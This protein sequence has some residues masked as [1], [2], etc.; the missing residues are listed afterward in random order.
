M[1]IKE[2]LSLQIKYL[3]S[4]VALA[5]ILI[6]SFAGFGLAY[7]GYQPQLT[8]A[9]QEI[10]E[11]NSTCQSLIASQ[12]TLKANYSYL[13]KQYTSLNASVNALQTRVD[14]L[15]TNYSNLLKQYTSL[16]ASLNALQKNYTRLQ[17]QYT[18]INASLNTLKTSFNILQNQVTSLNA[19]LNALKDYVIARGTGSSYYVYKQNSTY[20]AQNGLNGTVE[21]HDENC[22]AVL[23]YAFS[24]VPR[25]GTMLLK[26]LGSAVDAYYVNS[27][28]YPRSDTTLASENKMV[29]I[30]LE[31]NSNEDVISLFNVANVQIRDI[32][33]YGNR[34][35]NTNGSGIAISSDHSYDSNQVIENVLIEDCPDMGIWVQQWPRNNVFENVQPCYCGK[36]GVEIDSSDQ[37]L[38]DV[39][40]GW[41][42][43]SGF[44]VLGMDNYLTN[45]IS[46]GS[47]EKETVE[48]NGFIVSNYRNMFIGCDA[49]ANYGGGFVLAHANQSMLSS[50]VARDNGQANNGLRIAGRWGFDLYNTESTILTGCVSTNAA[51][52]KTQDYGFCEGGNSDYNVVTDCNFEGNRI[53]A[54]FALVGLYSVI[55]DT[56]G[57][58]TDSF[59]LSNFRYIGASIAIG[60]ADAYRDSTN[61]TSAKGEI[62]DFHVTIG[63]SNMSSNEN[64][65]V[66]VQGLN[67][68]GTATSFE[69]SRN[70]NGVYILTE[71]DISGLWSNNTMLEA[72]LVSAKTTENATQA[73][74]SVY[75]WGSGN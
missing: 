55:R 9:L 26:P 33:I 37:H 31:N 63:W 40:S 17:N 25:G 46:W 69:T 6:A 24:H 54:V 23:S 3:I 28:I 32:T 4:V 11:L 43:L 53:G 57:Y 7:L 50:C 74:V 49:S 12:D 14:T 71:N 58:E 75:V 2:L 38:T 15:Q 65:T 30:C 16:S 51:E 42:G 44:K 21:N 36:Y 72:I 22:S 20:Y 47:G 19:S 56:L 70:D 73:T 61:F 45:C 52:T 68:N 8:H 10:Q 29:T 35:H 67:A 18:G 66:R 64:V 5:S 34:E 1:I 62:R 48:S 60:V 13:L 41:A 27:T 59:Q 39:E